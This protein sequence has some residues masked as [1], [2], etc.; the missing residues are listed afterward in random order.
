VSVSYYLF[1]FCPAYLCNFHSNKRYEILTKQLSEAGT[2]LY[3]PKNLSQT[4]WSCRADATKAIARRYEKINDVLHEISNDQEQKDVVR[5]EAAGLYQKMCSLEIAL[6]TT[7][8]NDIMQRFNATNHILQDPRM[9]LQSAAMGL[10]SLKLYVYSKRDKF[11]EYEDVAKKMSG[12][13]EYVHALPRQIN[14]KPNPLNFDKAKEVQKTPKEK[15]R[16]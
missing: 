3:V 15:F 7:F 6:Y 12:T 14:V 9:V 11:D 5:N 1:R 8:W 16:T 13:E 2:K 10:K 4:S